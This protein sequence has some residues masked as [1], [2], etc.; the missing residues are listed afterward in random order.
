MA[1]HAQPRELAALKGADKKNPQRYRKEAPRSGLPLGIAPDHLTDEQ[2]ACWFELESCALHGVLTGADRAMME[3]ASKLLNE[4][5]SNW[6]D[7]S[8]ARMGHMIGI[9][10]RLG[11]SPADRQK[12]GAPSDDVANPFDHLDS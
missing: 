9:L 1:R 2:K 6:V 4:S 7:F 11:L 10:A 3:L 12:L 8:A 5:R